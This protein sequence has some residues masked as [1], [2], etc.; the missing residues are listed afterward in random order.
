M[1]LGLLIFIFWVVVIAGLYS[2]GKVQETEEQVHVRGRQLQSDK[3]M[4][5]DLEDD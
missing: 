5:G 3:Q 2:F 1:I 4:Q